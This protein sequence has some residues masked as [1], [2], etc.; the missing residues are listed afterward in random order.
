M[1]LPIMK[2]QL[3]KEFKNCVEKVFKVLCRRFV[4]SVDCC[5]KSD[6]GLS[7][8]RIVTPRRIVCRRIVGILNEPMA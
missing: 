2:N 1:T 6:G 5:T 7:C 8:R 3:V 4:V